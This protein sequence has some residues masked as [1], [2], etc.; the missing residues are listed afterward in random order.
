MTP[1]YLLIAALAAAVCVLT[2]TARTRGLRLA[3]LWTARG[4]VFA[5]VI[6]IA[7]SLF[8]ANAMTADEGT[9]EWARDMWSLWLRVCFVYTLVVGG[10]TAAAALTRHQFVRVRRIVS[11]AGTLFLLLLGR[12]YGA[13]CRTDAIALLPP[14][15]VLTA[16]C[17]LTILFP[18]A[19]EGPDRP[20]PKKKK[21]SKTKTPRA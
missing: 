21:T 15:V 10:V 19:A 6:C 2:F 1:L 4:A 11:L 5:G 3:V 12:A 13:M 14:V 17:A 8:L 16:G 7:V 9:L 18:F 20:L